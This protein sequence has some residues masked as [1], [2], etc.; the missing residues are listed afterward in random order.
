M[1]A[2]A[3][4]LSCKI[5]VLLG[6]KVMSDHE[7]L[8]I[9]FDVEIPKLARFLNLD[10]VKIHEYC[11][12][13]EADHN[14]LE[15]INEKI[16]GIPEFNGK[17]FQHTSELRV[18]RTMLY[19]IVRAIRPTTMVETGV[20][21]GFGSAFTLLAMSHSGH[22][23][24]HSIDIPPDDPRMASQ[25]TSPLPKGKSA[26]W[27]IPDNLRSRHHL[28]FGGAEV[29]LPQFL[30]ELEARDGLQVFL[31]DS[32]HCYTHMIFELAIA[33]RYIQPGGVIVCDNVE[34]NSAFFDLVRAVEG[35]STVLQS[36]A[37]AA[38]RWEHGLLFRNDRR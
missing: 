33:W 25:G 30:A 20:L 19:V 23:T 37:S 34:Q 15:A 38:R 21:N 3:N 29:L 5:L 11:R 35:N 36:F 10:E 12:E 9:S 18:F 31:H 24:L 26:G 8:P 28:H 2:L 1:H 22:G 16:E 4:S 7:S 27:V 32:D 17:I 6:R 13:L 14:F